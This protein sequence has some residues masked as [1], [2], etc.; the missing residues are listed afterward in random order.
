LLGVAQHRGAGQEDED[1]IRTA[2]RHIASLPQLR[3]LRRLALGPTVAAVIGRPKLRILCPAK[4]PRL[5]G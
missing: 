1:G 3:A 2:R 4:M 5:G